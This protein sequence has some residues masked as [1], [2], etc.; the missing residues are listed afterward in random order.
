MPA[1]C[2]PSDDD[3]SREER[4]RKG[5]GPDL[6]CHLFQHGQQNEQHNEQN[7]MAYGMKNMAGIKEDQ[8]MALA[9]AG[10]GV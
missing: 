3:P 2:L 4:G 8:G 10:D 9:M 7:G 1:H 5:W 6:P